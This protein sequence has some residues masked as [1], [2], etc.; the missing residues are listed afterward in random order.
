MEKK[1]QNSNRDANHLDY[2]FV[3]K[4]KKKKSQK[5]RKLNYDMTDLANSHT[6][7]FSYLILNLNF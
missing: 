5:V 1:Y 6:I 7:N 3:T 4:K 2:I